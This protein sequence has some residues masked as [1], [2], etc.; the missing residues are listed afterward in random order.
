[1]GVD[2]IG[3]VSDRAS[4]GQA[5]GVYWAGFTAGSLARKGARGGMRGTGNKVGSDK[6]L[7]EVGRMVEGD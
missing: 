1:M 5:A 6:E 4:E 3:E 2:M 7:M